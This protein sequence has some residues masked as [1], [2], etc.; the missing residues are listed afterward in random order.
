MATLI[1]N[2]KIYVERDRFEEAML[3][4]EGVIQAIGTND[5]ML[6]K[7]GQTATLYDAQHRTIIPGFNDSH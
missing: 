3:I 6:D 7:Y 5:S 4:D 1:F 2:A